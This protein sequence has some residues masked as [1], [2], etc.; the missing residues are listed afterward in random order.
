MDKSKSSGL[1]VVGSE[2]VRIEN[3]FTLKV[4]QVFTGFGIGCGIG[5][6]VG[7][8]INLGIATSFLYSLL[9]FFFFFLSLSQKI[10]QVIFGRWT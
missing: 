2:R 4:G 9:F 1:V 7:R 10:A 6:G 5:I 8:P 3:P